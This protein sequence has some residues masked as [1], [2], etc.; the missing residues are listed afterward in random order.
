MCF[1][2]CVP[3]LSCTWLHSSLCDARLGMLH[4]AQGL[5]HT[6]AV[7][8][9]CSCE[10]L[11]YGAT[12]RTDCR[13]AALCLDVD[14]ALLL[15]G[16]FKHISDFKSPQ[17]VSTRTKPSQQSS[18]LALLERLLGQELHPSAR[19]LLVHPEMYLYHRLASSAV[20]GFVFLLHYHHTHKYLCLMVG[21]SR[22]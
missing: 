11:R 12:L 13:T 14:C 22:Q 2:S 20:T 8:W 19:H 1:N 6:F 4:L 16:H 15:F 18:G 3:V 21:Q 17:M 9:L 10:V 7:L 5:V